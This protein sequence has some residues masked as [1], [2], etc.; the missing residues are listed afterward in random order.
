M[1]K[2]MFVGRV[3]AG[4]H[5]FFFEIELNFTKFDRDS[6]LY[7]RLHGTPMKKRFK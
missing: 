3:F 7:P 1:S 5:L 2:R 6:S 4:F